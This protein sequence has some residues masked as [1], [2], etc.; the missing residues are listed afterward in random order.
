MYTSVPSPDKIIASFPYPTLHKVLEGDYNGCAQ[1]R[2]EL[3]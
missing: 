2:K 3:K 1:A